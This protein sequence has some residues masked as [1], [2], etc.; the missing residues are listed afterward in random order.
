MYLFTYLGDL[1][2]LFSCVLNHQLPFQTYLA[3]YFVCTDLIL[4]YQYFRYSNVGSCTDKVPDRPGDEESLFLT[5]HSTLE[6]TSTTDSNILPAIKNT[7][8]GSTQTSSK[9]TSFMALLL[10]GFR[11]SIVLVGVQQKSESIN[12]GWALAWICTTF[13]ILSRIP[14]IYKNFKRQS[15]EGLSIALFSFA[16]CGNITYALSILCH[17]GHTR[18]TLL[19]SL[20]YVYGS[21]GTLFFDAVIFAQFLNYRKK[22]DMIDTTVTT[23][24]AR[25]LTFE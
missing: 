22:E 9:A 7:Y 5:R 15:T 19:E 8:Y 6:M 17:P 13:Y 10:F 20:P 4:I 25:I 14:Q 11:S 3:G 18:E 23:S 2:N 12:F 1:G 24:L 21:F 16:V